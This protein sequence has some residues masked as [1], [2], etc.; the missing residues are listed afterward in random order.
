MQFYR[1]GIRVALMFIGALIL[2]SLLMFR[3][4]ES[5]LFEETRRYLFYFDF[6]GNMTESAPV[7]YAGYKIGEI[8]K[9]RI[10]SDEERKQ[11]PY[12]LEVTVRINRSVEL[13]EGALPQIKTMGF[14]GT[15]YIDIEP[16]QIGK[17]PIDPSIPLYGQT[18]QDVNE[19]IGRLSAQVEEIIPIVKDT[20]EKIHHA[21][22]AGEGIVA[23]VAEDRKI[24]KILDDA[25]QI[26]V[27]LQESVREIQNMLQENTPKISNTMTNV[28]EFSDDLKVT[29]KSIAPKVD[30]VIT[31]MQDV[32]LQLEAVIQG[33]KKLVQENKP[34]VEKI[35]QNLE[36]ASFHA[37]KFLEILHHN[38][39]KLLAKPK[40]GSE[41]E[42]KRSKKFMAPGGYVYR[43]N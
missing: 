41:D 18:A 1:T 16:G 4:N 3:V 31:K 35:V 38:P 21:V 11:I 39:W 22:E 8:E 24:Q 32:V 23:D 42:K 7:T 9:I 37:K 40:K 17:P 2:L 13:K 28:E 26:L 15:K 19:V 36:E 25:Q 30:S 6:I 10:L 43:K 27:Q 29:F 33:T 5:N 20:V 34:G 14:L 12:T